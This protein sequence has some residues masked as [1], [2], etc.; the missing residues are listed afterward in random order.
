MLLELPL[1][2]IA[3]GVALSLRPWRGL[4][5]SRQLLPWA[6]AC[7]VLPLL[8]AS[9]R[10]LPGG[11]VLQLSGAC[12]LTLMTG[13]PLAVLALPV[14]ALVGAALGGQQLGAAI[15]LLWW[16]GVLPATLTL[17]LGALTRHALPHHLFVYILGRG[18]LGTLIC[19]G[20]AGTLAALWQ[21]LPP[22]TSL[23]DLV[24]AHW[25]LASGEAFATGM[26]V[27]IFVA[28]RP[29]WLATHSDALYLGTAER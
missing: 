20:L 22:N 28:Y 25:L 6:I 2:A 18:F 13:W 11:L 29:H 1:T 12:L 15:G 9:Q 23:A 19:L 10:A 21:T 7:A 24:L 4:R 17:A 26:L 5:G 8:W 14:V 3:F 16:N 27:A